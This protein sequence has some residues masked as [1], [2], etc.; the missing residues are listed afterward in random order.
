MAL[1]LISVALCILR[2]KSFVNV[3]QKY[4]REIKL[5]I[6]GT[7]VGIM[8][9]ITEIFY[10]F[11]VLGELTLMYVSILSA[12]LNPIVY[13]IMDQ[14]LREKVLFVFNS[15]P[16]SSAVVPATHTS[17]SHEVPSRLSAIKPNSTVQ[18]ESAEL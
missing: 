6:Q 10:Y 3:K 16:T 5:L 14:R 12:S 4:V 2:Y 7:I 18:I 17:V 8:L 15:R 13:L 1:H 9:A 11:P